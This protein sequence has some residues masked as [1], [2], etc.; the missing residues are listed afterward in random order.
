MAGRGE[1]GFSKL[2]NQTLT[3]CF[4]T[5]EKQEFLT[6]THIFCIFFSVT[7]KNPFSLDEDDTDF[8]SSAKTTGTTEEILT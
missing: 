4:W 3:L 5:P 7:I 2:Y 6:T 8:Y 1:K